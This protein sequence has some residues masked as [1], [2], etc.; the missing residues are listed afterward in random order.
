MYQSPFLVLSSVLLR[1]SLRSREAERRKER[2]KNDI[3]LFWAFTS[4][5]RRICLADLF[6]ASKLVMV[7]ELLRRF[8]EFYPIPALI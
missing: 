2:G 6:S 1:F 4:P 7:F 5:S 8:S 3:Q